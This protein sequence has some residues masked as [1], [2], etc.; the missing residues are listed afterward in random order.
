MM[1]LI[2][3]LGN[4]GDK[5]KTT[6]H[7]LGFMVLDALS[8]RLGTKFDREK[9][10]WYARTNHESNELV[11]V[12]PRTYMN[13]SGRA[14]QQA[15][16]KYKVALSQVLITCDDFH[17]PLGKVRLR[18]KGS[19]GGHKGLAS[20]IQHLKTN[21]FPRLRIGIGFDFSEKE[22]VD[23]VLSSFTRKEMVIIKK[24]IEF[25]CEAVLSFVTKGIENTMN[26]FNIVS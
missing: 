15:V 24:K 21:E 8:K 1:F 17:L 23:F 13:L 20:I 18:S 6:R 19:N 26:D 7:N 4:P 25:A 14:V 22:T 2:V 9:L 16:D 10:Y 3:G 12:K 5:Y 11:L